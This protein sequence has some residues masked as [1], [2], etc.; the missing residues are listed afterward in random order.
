MTAALSRIATYTPTIVWGTG[1]AIDTS[2]YDDVSRYY[3]NESGLVINGIGRDQI[4][5]YAPPKA[6]SFDLT[7]ANYDGTF[8]PGGPLQNFL[9]RGPAVFLDVSY[10]TDVLVDAD[11]VLVDAADQLADGYMTRRFF[12]GTAISMP[13]KI[14]N[15]ASVSVTALGS[16]ATLL[17]G[18]K[19]LT[20]LYENITTDQAITAILDWC[21]WS[22]TKRAI[23][24][25]STT[26][27][28]WWLNGQTTALAAINMLLAAEGAGA[29]AYED[30]DGVFH[31]EGRAFRETNPRSVTTQWIFSDGVTSGNATVDDE[32]V[33][34]DANDVLVDGPLVDPLF[35]VVPAQYMSNP[36][37]VVAAVTATVNVRTPT[38]PMAIW[39]YG[40]TLTLTANQVLDVLV[41]SSDP[42][43]DAITPVAD[44]VGPEP[45][46][47]VVT[48]GSLVSV[49]LLS[50][51][52][53]TITSRWTAGAS[54]A[55][56]LGV[57]SA[58]PQVRAVSLPVTSILP[59]QS[60]V[61]TDTSARTQAQD[62]LTLALWPEVERNGALD[63]VNSFVLRYRRERR[64]AQFQV[65]NLDMAHMYAILN[66]RISDR[67]QFIHT[68]ADLNIVTW[69]EQLAYM[70]AP[71]GGL[72]M[73][74]IGAEQVFDLHGG[75]FDTAQYDVDVF[76]LG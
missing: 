57:T 20:I 69:A 66:M 5:A 6:P 63:I 76:G 18:K 54:G 9:G 38:E 17:V 50:T 21:G 35:H 12:D 24:T 55:T 10:G 37:E 46:D 14:D 3:L 60:T 75:V 49:A 61:S 15:P 47:Y 45:Y 44:G 7:L 68:R 64:Q 27:L 13:Q 4:R 22:A 31:W 26:L 74:T 58:G 51:S 48:D 41:T 42:F 25:S 59:V 36:D 71:G 43:K 23:S 29:C 67:V 70:I 30:G 28:Y 1:T 53:Q 2:A 19:P 73:L 65:V 34:T 32:M 8:A 11:D 16:M 52:G 39:E 40:G 56:I 33:L 72:I 62:P